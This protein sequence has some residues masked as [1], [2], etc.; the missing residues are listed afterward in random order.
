LFYFSK[1]FENNYAFI[2]DVVTTSGDKEHKGLIEVS[3]ITGL[4]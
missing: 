2:I 1:F 4:D 3:L